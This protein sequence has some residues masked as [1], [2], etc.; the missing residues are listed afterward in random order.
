MKRQ[1][2]QEGELILSQ[3][4]SLVSLPETCLEKY[5]CMRVHL[6]VYLVLCAAT[7]TYAN[8]INHFR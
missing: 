1:R 6:H 2:E 4:F 3:L 5:T 8:Y 7:G